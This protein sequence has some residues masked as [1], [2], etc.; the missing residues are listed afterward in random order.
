MTTASAP[1]PRPACGHDVAAFGAVWGFQPRDALGL[2]VFACGLLGSC[3][4]HGDHAEVDVTFETDAK[5]LHGTA[6]LV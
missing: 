2:A 6:H 1:R 5:G 4:D 3:L